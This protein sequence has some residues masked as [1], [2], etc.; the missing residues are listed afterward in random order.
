MKNSIKRQQGLTLISIAFI[1]MGLGTVILLGMKI[2]PIYMDHSKV[3]NALA[4]VEATVDIETKSKQ[5]IRNIIAKRFNFNYVYKVTA[6]DAKITK[7]AG[8]LRVEFEYEVVEPL[9]GNLSALV[10][11][12]DV[13]EVGEE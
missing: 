3:V 1:L 11:F 12:H 4:A 5:E 2:V 8:Y 9:V 6:A 7:H 10:E 13:I